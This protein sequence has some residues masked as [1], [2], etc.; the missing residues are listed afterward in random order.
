MECE[1]KNV[2][3]SA[4]KLE[5][6]EQ[7]INKVTQNIQIDQAQVQEVLGKSKRIQQNSN[8]FGERIKKGQ[9]VSL[10]KVILNTSN[11]HVGFG[12]DSSDELTVSHDIDVEVFMLTDNEKIVGDDWFVFYNK[13]IS[14]D[15]SIK[16]LSDTTTD[17]SKY[18]DRSV[19]VDFSKI[20]KSVSKLVFVVTINDAISRNHNFG[21]IKNVYI[22]I[23]DMSKGNEVYRYELM[24][25]YPNV[26]SMVVGEVY[27]H[28]GEWK[29]N[30]VG[31]GTSD[32]LLGLCKR[33]GV[34]VK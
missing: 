22:R 13:L 12:W 31:D 27:K 6:M 26:I 4:I 15:E 23:V 11:I 5:E 7:E 16:I 19:L 17:L 14:P 29:F 24:E 9:K 8:T 28:N 20:N 18:D 25:Y 32:D 10:S 2:V 34:D 33:Y 21:Q 1:I 30:P 3:K